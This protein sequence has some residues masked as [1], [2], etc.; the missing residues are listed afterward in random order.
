MTI[1]GVPPH[2]L[3]IRGGHY[4][5]IQGEYGL[6]MQTLQCFPLMA[7]IY[8]E[9]GA[10]SLNR[11]H[12]WWYTVTFTPGADSAGIYLYIIIFCLLVGICWSG[13]SPSDLA[14]FSAQVHAN[15]PPAPASTHWDSRCF[16]RLVHFDLS[17]FNADVPPIHQTEA[18]SAVAADLAKKKE[19]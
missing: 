1:G 8:L 4:K 13:R 2:G 14:V 7:A 17:I 12:F 16:L 19:E 6:K 18:F 10:I 3:L 15:P 9:W 5:A 11:C